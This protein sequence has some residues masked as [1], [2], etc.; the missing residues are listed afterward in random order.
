MQKRLILLLLLLV[1]LPTAVLCL[2]AV[3]SLRGW[4]L[5]LQ[6]RMEV[7]AERAAQAAVNRVDRRI[8]DDL[9]QIEMIMADNLRHGYSPDRVSDAVG[10]LRQAHPLIDEAYLFMSP[11]GFVFPPS[12]EP[13]SEADEAL[14]AV[15]RRE[16]ARA[17]TG[18]PIRFKVGGS[19][20]A[21]RRV[22][23]SASL[24]AGYRVAE[25][26][27]RDA[28][29]QAISG[30]VAEGFVLE[31]RGPGLR[32]ASRE[33]E[34]GTVVVSDSLGGEARVIP[35]SADMFV[36]ARPLARVVWE[37]PFD[38][39]EVLAFAAD[40]DGMTGSGRHEATLRGWGIFVLAGGI[41]I[42]AWVVLYGA[43]QE[44][45]RLRARSDF[46]LGVSHDL[47][48]P[49]ASMRVLAE[50]LYLGRVSSDEKKR[51][52][53]GTLLQEC[54]RLHQLVERVLF[55]VRYGQNALVLDRRQ[56]DIES[57]AREAARIFSAYVPEGSCGDPEAAAKGRPSADG[58]GVGEETRPEFHVRI[59]PD[60]PM[61]RLDRTAFLQVLLNLLDNA[62][63]Y[64]RY[65]SHPPSGW[66]PVMALEV[67]RERKRH[68]VLARARDWI[69]LRVSDNGPGLSA[70]ERRRLFRPFYRTPDAGKKNVSGVGLGLALC[71]H[72]VRTHGGVITVE[73]RPG[74]GSVFII[75]LPI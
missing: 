65:E 27:L 12:S 50:S 73:S 56:D 52:F 70:S 33:W 1:I 62:H 30:L 43:L 68:H 13:P 54:D 2:L 69:S 49:L 23:T 45:R 64:G 3:R 10:T 66:R 42:G 8:L 51:Q 72:V 39:Y 32:V 9:D 20:Y 38:E 21:F 58:P 34:K 63:K 5:I 28:I 46:V 17:G 53:L 74:Q 24:H 61:V 41:C 7:G 67:R 44:A 22:A 14:V 19:F 4:E 31:A 40:P 48:T 55:L 29:H 75:D 11:W 47:R 15:L 37:A 16:T 57:V 35:P 59:E 18:E 60:L 26:A 25:D 6:R 36:R 71:R